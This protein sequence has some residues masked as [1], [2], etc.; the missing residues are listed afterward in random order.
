MT[1]TALSWSV[2]FAQYYSVLEQLA[3]V[4]AVIILISSLDDLFIDVWFWTRE[5][6]R[7]FRIKKAANYKPLTPEQIKERDEQHLA[8]MVPAWL[9]YDVIASMIESMV[10]TLDYRNYTVFVGT[11][12]NDHATIEEVERMRRRYKQLRRVEVPHDGPTCK[13]DCLNWVVQAI[14]LHEKQADIE[15]A[16]VILHDSEDV[17]HP[18]ELKFFNYLLPRKDMI[19]LPVAS[20]E[21][22]WFELVAGTYMDEFAEWHAKDLVVRES[23]AGSVP[24]AGVGTCFSR[25]ALL[26]LAASTDNQPFNTESLT[27]DY[28]VGNR[29]A[30]MGMQSIFAIFPVEFQTRSRRWF[31][32]GKEQDRVITMPLCVREFFPDTF[33]TSYR[34]KARWVLGISMQNWEQMGWKGS[35]AQKYLLFRDRKGIIT[36]LVSILAYVVFFQFMLFYL[37]AEAGIWKM[38][39]PAIFAPG[40]FLMTVLSLTLVAL[41][42]RVVQRVY[43]V[44][45]L[46]GWEHGLMSMPRMV[47]GNFINFMAVCRAWKLFSGYLL[48]GKNMVWD[49]TMHDFPSSS[50]LAQKRQLLGEVLTAWHAVDDEKIQE[51]LDERS[52]ANMSLGRILI[53][54]GW[55]DEET[56]AEAIAFQSDLPRTHINAAMVEQY[57]GYISS[58]LCMRMRMLYI[59]NDERER[60]IVA[61]AGPLSETEMQELSLIFGFNPVQ[62][63]VRDSEIAAGLRLLRGESNAFQS[64]AEGAAG[65]PLLGDLLIER[66]LVQRQAFEA[67]MESYRPGEHGRIGDYLVSCGVIE[68]N[69]IEQVVEEQRRQQ[70]QIIQKSTP[71]PTM[72]E[73]D[74]VEA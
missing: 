67:A 38:R 36:S 59:G 14:F 2:F 50:H 48:M 25:R 41:V 29:L 65:V 13:A 61:V 73:D 40:S 66:G 47:I 12:V 58:E 63:I 34:Q 45:R 44:T 23:V 37:A 42:L 32:F 16:G 55:L 15:F 71:L 28:D 35:L 6:Y 72:I 19:Q 18:L 7:K 57:A 4:V 69:V 24:S 62:H 20:L 3:V 26:T 31:G 51:A 49:K 5:L 17:L 33:R 43:F 70:P 54:K 56:L 52:S 30:A 64:L 68:R 9:E 39:F 27:E 46:Y 74:K 22:E 53:S 10:A 1:F 60:P 11:Y 8:I 21:R